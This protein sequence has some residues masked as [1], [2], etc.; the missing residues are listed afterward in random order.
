[1][2]EFNNKHIQTN[3]YL[4]FQLYLHIARN[5]FLLWLE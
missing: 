5:P 1:M 2:L 3:R 4:S